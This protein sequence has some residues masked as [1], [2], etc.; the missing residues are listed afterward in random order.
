M[1]GKKGRDG[2]RSFLGLESSA[3][4][5][6]GRASIRGRCRRTAGMSSGWGDTPTGRE[7]WILD[8]RI[9][10]PGILLPGPRVI[11]SVPEA[12]T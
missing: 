5:R 9:D 7:G 6:T 2:W 12:S 11:L 8:R 10:P 1:R 4:G 3:T